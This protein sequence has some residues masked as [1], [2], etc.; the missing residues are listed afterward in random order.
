MPIEYCYRV[1]SFELTYSLMRADKCWLV[2]NMLPDNNLIRALQV[3]MSAL[4]I[5]L[6]KD[7]M[8]SQTGSSPS[9]ACVVFEQDNPWQG[10][11]HQ[12]SIPLPKLALVTNNTKWR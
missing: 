12:W 5:V 4:V 9:V 7:E 1:A 8:S 6:V 10:F 3:S 11:L 2:S